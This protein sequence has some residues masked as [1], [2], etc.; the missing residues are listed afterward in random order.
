MSPGILAQNISVE[1]GGTSSFTDVV[2]VERDPTQTVNQ[3]IRLKID[4]EKTIFSIVT[5]AIFPLLSQ[6]NHNSWFKTLNTNTAVYVFAS[7]STP[8]TIGQE[9]LQVSVNDP[10]S[11][12]DA[13]DAI[14]WFISRTPRITMLDCGNVHIITASDNERYI[15]SPLVIRGTIPSGL[16]TDRL[17]ARLSGSSSYELCS[18]EFH[19]IGKDGY[20]G[21]LSIGHYQY[22]VSFGI[23]TFQ[24][25]NFDQ[26][27][28]LTLLYDNKV[29][30][31]KMLQAS[32]HDSF[33]TI[34]IPK[35]RERA[36]E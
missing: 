22:D 27:F 3:D 31:E 14:V 19:D 24:E 29:V 23:R 36:T 2:I 30:A 11:T 15:K 21:I 7:N 33:L 5:N 25:V 35:P 13:F 12:S 16:S 9:T 32:L 6:G 8:H 26:S 17:A 34:D 28:I 20:I 4:E 10:I 1:R 18:C